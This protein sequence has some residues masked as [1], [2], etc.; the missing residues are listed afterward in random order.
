MLQT[1]GLL[2]GFGRPM[3]AWVDEG[4]GQADEVGEGLWECLYNMV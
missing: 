4:K 2:L 1:L 3:P